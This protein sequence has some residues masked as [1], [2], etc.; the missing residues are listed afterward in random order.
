MLQQRPDY[1]GQTLADVLVSLR[2]DGCG[3]RGRLTVHLCA[4][5][6]GPG[7][8]PPAV[9]SGWSLLLHDPTELTFE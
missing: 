5:A 1:A 6:H 8:L 2:C 7:A 4:S 9:E 3:G